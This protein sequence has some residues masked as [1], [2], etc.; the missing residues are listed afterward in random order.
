[1]KRLLLVLTVALMF[2]VGAASPAYAAPQSTHG[3]QEPHGTGFNFDGTRPTG[4]SGE[5]GNFGGFVTTEQTGCT[6]INNGPFNEFTPK[7]KKCH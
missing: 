3:P 4:A 2:A 1:M 6:P 5:A 7:T